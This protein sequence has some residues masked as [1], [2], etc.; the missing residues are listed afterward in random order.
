[1]NGYFDMSDLAIG[2]LGCHRKGLIDAK[3]LKCVEYAARGIP[4]IYS[5]KNSDF[6]ECP[7]VLKIPQDES[8]VNI[9][10]ILK[11]FYNTKILPD[12]MRSYVRNSLTWDVQ[13]KRVLLFSK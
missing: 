12:E 6:D 10:V 9:D 5:D 2:S 3:P 7:F 1:M 4:F 11:F 13:M 8:P